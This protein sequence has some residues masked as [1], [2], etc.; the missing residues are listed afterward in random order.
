M[1]TTWSSTFHYHFE[2][3]ETVSLMQTLLSWH[4]WK[5]L[6]RCCLRS[7]TFCLSCMLYLPCSKNAN[8]TQTTI[9]QRQ[10]NRYK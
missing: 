8:P 7:P 3:L 6:S 5:L 10:S 2:S 4:L 9:A 1:V